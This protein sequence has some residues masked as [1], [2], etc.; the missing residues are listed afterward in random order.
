MRSTAYARRRWTNRIMIGLCTAFTLLAVAVLLLILGYTLFHG[1]RH[2]DWGFITEAAR[3]MGEAGGGM[4]NEIIGTLILVALAGAIGVPV[5]LMC[6]IFLA[7]FGG[8]KVAGGVRFIA[9]V[10]TGLPSIVV[11]VFAYAILVRPLG[12]FS[13][14]AGGVALAIIMIPIIARTAEESLRL[15]S[16]AVREGALALGIPR[17]RAVMSVII[18]GASTGIITGVLLAMARAAG[19][20][21]PLLFT[22]LGNYF[23]FQGLFEPSSALPLAIYQ[24]ATSPYRVDQEQAWAA[25]VVLVLMIL[26]ISMAVRWLTARGRPSRG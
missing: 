2:L 1:F 3:P 21:A 24:N 6:G 25:A 14:L 15:V 4:R 9:D 18:P 13:V 16:P 7:E 26:A 22:S 20:T 17:W 19:E 12:S 10:L 11:G 8:P 5:G 23:G